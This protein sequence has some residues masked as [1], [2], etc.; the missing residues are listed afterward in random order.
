MP[1]QNVLAFQT[2]RT[3]EHLLYFIV[4]LALKVKLKCQCLFI[5]D[6]LRL[7]RQKL[8]GN[9]LYLGWYLP[10]VDH[11]HH[12]S[13]TTHYFLQAERCSILVA[14]LARTTMTIL[15]HFYRLVR[16]SKL[17]YIGVYVFAG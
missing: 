4:I 16:T 3:K 9:R 15:K 7:G 1:Q 5:S 13:F 14:I 2:R 11:H 8:P 10:G 12:P 17:I 6:W